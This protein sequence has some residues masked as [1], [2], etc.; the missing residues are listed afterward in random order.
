MKSREYIIPLT[1]F[2]IYLLYNKISPIL[3][4]YKYKI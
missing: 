3:K 2:S 1:G 4:K